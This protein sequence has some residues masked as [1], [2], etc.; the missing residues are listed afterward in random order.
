[1]LQRAILTAAALATVLFALPLA[2]AVS[3][4][5]R[6]EAT[7]HLAQDAERV[8]AAV[9]EEA[10]QRG[11]VTAAALP[12][13]RTERADVGVYSLAGV[14]IVGN[15]PERAESL[16][17]AV[18]QDGLER[19]AVVDGALVVAVS[20]TDEDGRTGY[21]VRAAQ[22][23]SEV[24]TRTY[25]TWVGML[26]LAAVVLALVAA[27][28]RSRARR[29][30]IPLQ[31][32]AQV[33]DD[34]G[35]GDFTVRAVRAGVAEVDGVSASLE[36]TARRLGGMLERERAFSADASHQLRTPLTAVRVGLEAALLTPGADL[37]AAARDALGSL[38]R[39]EQ[40]VMDLLS[41]ARDTAGPDDRTRPAAVVTEVSGAWSRPV[42]DAGRELVV[43][44]EDD[45]PEVAV[46][47]AAL[48]TTLDVLLSNALVHG[49]GTV[50]V[51]AR[52]TGDV[53]VVDVADEGPGVRGDPA[54]AFVRRAGEGRGTGIGL[55]LARSLVEADGGRLELT[56]ATP[57]TFAVLLP[58]AR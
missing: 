46:S 49:A 44:V 48:R 17:T 37:E 16:V 56:R 54:A 38:D 34:L 52:D 13:P 26:V 20:V 40:T 32:L 7:S 12:R 8:R 29:I 51:R 53:V 39:L 4:L 23:I 5:Y 6:D 25:L 45:L 31:T 36:R 57:P 1:V 18:G 35:N 42:A 43:G 2:V 24:S 10:L 21:V 41:L 47:A 19:D 28:A 30:A 11:S 15:G 9:G 22:P 55:A 58:I 50:T 3:G 27:L 14:R 33:A